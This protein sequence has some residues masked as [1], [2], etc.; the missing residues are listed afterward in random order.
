[1]TEPPVSGTGDRLRDAYHAVVEAVQPD[2][3]G[4]L[5]SPQPLPRIAGSG[6]WTRRLAPLAAAAAVVLA[7]GAAVAIP[8]LAGHGTAV[9]TAPQTAGVSSGQPPFLVDLGGATRLYLQ[10]RDAA[11][12]R[13]LAQL[14]PPEGDGRWAAVAATGNP[15]RFVV[16]ATYLRVPG[17]LY[18]TSSQNYTQ[19]YTLTLTA[20]GVPASLSPLYRIPVL[21]DASVPSGS[22]NALAVSADGRTVAYAAAPCGHP[23]S[24]TQMSIVVIRDGV[25][26]TWT[27]PWTAG[28]SSLS[29]SADGSQLGYADIT[30]YEWPISPLGSAWILPTGSPPGSA[31]RWS[32][33]LLSN[34][35]N[36]GVQI[37]D[38]EL[39]PDGAIMYVVTATAAGNNPNK[40]TTD[41]LYAYSTASG[42]RL[43]TLHSWNGTT[44]GPPSL[45]IGGDEALVWDMYNW[46]DEVNLRTGSD[47][48]FTQLPH[49]GSNA[50]SVFTVA[51]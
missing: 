5:R 30:Q 33:K 37:T 15:A 11:T 3:I 44:S 2:D 4:D 17:V 42:A 34:V 43:R 12:G 39:S 24:K 13:V 27:T 38:E 46:V 22:R 14:K 51:W 35:P 48:T 50:G 7:L 6:R 1:M 8:R 26:R 23:T 36:A 9:V 32:R 20:A 47:R 29:L 10:V 41:A 45:T 40:P 31:A 28:P 19:L 25:S 16:G 18:C 21:F 49:G